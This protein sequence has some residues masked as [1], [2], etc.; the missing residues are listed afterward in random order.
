[1]TETRSPSGVIV[2]Y[3]PG[4][5]KAHGVA[6][7]VVDAGKPVTITS[8]LESNEEAITL[9]ERLPGVLGLGVGAHCEPHPGEQEGRQRPAS[10]DPLRWRPS[11]GGGDTDAATA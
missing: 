5:T 1:V 8:T 10:F 11:A 2:G 9:L 4:G 3:D 7:L 6:T